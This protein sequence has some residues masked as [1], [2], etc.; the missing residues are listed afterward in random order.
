[1]ALL[2]SLLFMLADLCHSQ[3]R[4]P[5]VGDSFYVYSTTMDSDL[6]EQ[7]GLQF[8]TIDFPCLSK[9]KLIESE[10]PR[11]DF[12]LKDQSS[13]ESLLINLSDGN[14]ILKG[15]RVLDPYFHL[16][17]KYIQL[18]KGIPLIN[19]DDIEDFENGGA[20]NYFLEYKVSDLPEQMENWA[21]LREYEKL[22]LKVSLEYETAFKGEEQ[23]ELLGGETYYKLFIKYSQRVTEIKMKKEGWEEIGL[24]Q[25][26]LSEQYFID[27]QTEYLSYHDKTQPFGSLKVYEQPELKIQ[28]QQKT[29]EKNLPLCIDSDEQ[30]YVYPN[31]SFGKLNVR[32]I[33][34]PEGNYTFDLYNIIG[35]KVWT[36]QL[37][38]GEQD[39]FN[40]E[41]PYL[42][43]G[44]YLYGIRDKN[45][46]LIQSRRLTIIEY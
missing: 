38:N 2:F 27:F 18:I 36:T 19:L 41:L 45:G 34:I 44:I 10:V 31:P 23:V 42:E 35:F 3:I 9:Q 13:G 43:K 8:Y 39:L 32:M 1:M 12:E 4:V 17:E 6:L 25:L 22:R 15:F 28:Y 21:S 26:P 16:S 5:V 11:I 29:K 40:L 30:V 14:I 46:R 7:E 37:T 20:E 24:E 33:N